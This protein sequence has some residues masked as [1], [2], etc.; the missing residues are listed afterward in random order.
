MEL[1]SPLLLILD[2]N[3]GRPAAKNRESSNF[4]SKNPAQLP[5][6]S[7]QVGRVQGNGGLLLH[8][9]GKTCDR[10]MELGL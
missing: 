4:P 10:D 8:L 9:C 3:F 5:S 2:G 7:C 6:L 1:S